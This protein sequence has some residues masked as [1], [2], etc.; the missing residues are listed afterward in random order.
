[1]WALNP[2]YIFHT[3]P[4]PWRATHLQ[5][6]LMAGGDVDVRDAWGHTAL[7]W[8]AARGHE[9]A[10]TALLAGKVCMA[11]DLDPIPNTFESQP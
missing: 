3:R 2:E 7:H 4:D 10:V 1:M 9:V 11:V 5:A 6:L 8:A